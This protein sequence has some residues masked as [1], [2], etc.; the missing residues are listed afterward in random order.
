MLG[1]VYSSTGSSN[2]NKYWQRTSHQKAEYPHQYQHRRTMPLRLTREE[3]TSQTQ[4]F[5]SVQDEFNAVTGRLALG[6]QACQRR[7]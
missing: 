2:A 6:R 1:Q 4:Y 7:I 3:R 5:H